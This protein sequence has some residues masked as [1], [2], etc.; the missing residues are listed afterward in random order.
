MSNPL[1][2]AFAKAESE[3]AAGARRKR[4][5]E[6]AAALAARD[7]VEGYREV[8]AAVPRHVT[9]TTE[10]ITLAWSPEAEPPSSVRPIGVGRDHRGSSLAFG[11]S[12]A[13]RFT[14]S[15]PEDKTR[16]EFFIAAD[17]AT[18]F[19]TRRLSSVRIK[20]GLGRGVSAEMIEAFVDVR[21]GRHNL[22]MDVSPGYGDE[23]YRLNRCNLLRPEKVAEIIA[24]QE[25]TRRRWARR[26]V[27]S[28]Q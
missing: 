25:L 26:R 4:E 27:S 19:T 3:R 14:R 10:E 1:D 13:W 7:L 21:T 9:A 24:E 11:D 15:H 28:S 12:H 20:R 16:T 17:C 23:P 6:R 2:D 22:W 5:K 18:V 8:L